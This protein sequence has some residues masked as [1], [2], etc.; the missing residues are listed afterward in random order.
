MRIKALF[1]IVLTCTLLSCSGVGEVPNPAPS[2]YYWRTTF[3]LTESQRDYLH[4]VKKLYL[5]LFDVVSTPQGPQPNATIS[6]ADTLP[7]GLAIIPTIF[8]DYTLFRQDVDVQDLAHHIVMRVAQM[9]ETHNFEYDEI[10]FDCDWTA[11]TEGGFFAFLKAVRQCDSSLTLSAT[12]RLHPLSM[13]PLPT[14]YGVLMLYNT[15]DYR[16]FSSERNPILDPRDVEP[17]LKYLKGYRLPLCAAYAHFSWHL[18]Y[19]EG[20]FRG[21]LYNENLADSTLFWPMGNNSYR[22]VMPRYIQVAQGAP[23]VHLSPG[24]VVRSWS[25]APEDW[26]EVEKMVQSQRPEINKQTI[27]YQ[28]S[29]FK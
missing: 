13:A 1:L 4:D 23:A 17:Y 26:L 18:L 15:G 28:L 27:V 20:E 7:S 19:H 9:A 2:V 16:D 14:D 6:F 29:D 3:A 12:I 8:I 25:V 24:D 10:Q 5:R 22:V 21:I 11:R